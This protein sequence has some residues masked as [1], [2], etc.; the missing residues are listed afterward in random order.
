M[1][2]CFV[3]FPSHHP[4]FFCP[5][6]LKACLVPPSPGAFSCF[7]CIF[8]FYPH[9]LPLLRPYTHDSFPNSSCACSPGSF[10]LSSP[11]LT[12]GTGFLCD[13]VPV[14]FLLPC[15]FFGRGFPRR[16]F[17]LHLAPPTPPVGRFVSFDPPTI[18]PGILFPFILSFLPRQ[19][20]EFSSSDV[21]ALFS[22]VPFTRYFLCSTTY[23]CPHTSCCQLNTSSLRSSCVDVPASAH[24]PL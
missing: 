16:K 9:P 21:E 8:F 12:T 6:C 14:P 18:M 22:S 15:T 2:G 5:R 13:L 19:R 10:R 7:L 23:C 17:A 24:L 4:L 20:S 3:N 11:F 1:G